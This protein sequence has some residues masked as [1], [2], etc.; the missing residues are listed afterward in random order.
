MKKS[1]VSTIETRRRIVSVASQLFLERG[2]AET[3]I[4]DVMAAAGLT[5]GGFYRH[6]ESKDQ[7]IAEANRA[8]NEDLFAHYDAA[9][10]GMAPAEA[11]KTIV[12]LYLDQSRE[13]AQG[14]LCPLANLG[15]E[16][17]HSNT[18]IR[19]A[20]MEGYQRLV[21]A[22]STLTGQLKIVD[23]QV[24]AETIVSSIVGAVTLAQLSV[25][26]I[27]AEGILA[28][29]ETSVQSMLQKFPK[30]SKR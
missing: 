25:D 20:A 30:T 19:S 21:G 5:Q 6:F 17:R 22:F 28:N 14:V 13:S 24:V 16:L 27:M 15:S 8:A 29:A 2:L 9:T 3:G 12:R 4:A 18:H 7:L 10:V 1:K 23:N 11:V 26:P